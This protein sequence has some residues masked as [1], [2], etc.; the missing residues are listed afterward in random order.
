MVEKHDKVLGSG[1]HPERNEHKSTFSLTTV[2]TFTILISLPQK[3]KTFTPPLG[4][5]ACCHIPRQPAP[6]ALLPSA[7]GERASTAVFAFHAPDC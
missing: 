3:Q 4:D 7:E 5:G 2:C 1:F 6:N